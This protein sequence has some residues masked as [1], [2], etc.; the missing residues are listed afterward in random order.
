VSVTILNSREF[1]P[2][3][4]FYLELYDAAT[5]LRLVGADTRT[6]ISIIDDDRPSVISFKEKGIIEHFAS[7]RHVR[8]SVQRLYHP[9]SKVTVKY[10]TVPI[11]K[12]A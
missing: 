5:G 2:D 11:N 12:E 4:E 10:R 6:T 7:D 1:E 8:V 3:E 9:D